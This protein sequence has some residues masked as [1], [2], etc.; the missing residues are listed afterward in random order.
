MQIGIFAKTYPGADPLTVLTR[1]AADGYACVQYNLACSGLASMPDSVS[2]EAIEAIASAS[3]AT[4]VRVVALSATYNMIHPDPDCRVLGMNR[5]GLSLEIAARLGIPTVTLCTGTRDSQDQWRHHPD[6]ETADAW[7]DLIDEMKKA[8]AKADALG[9]KLG[10]EPEQAN[11][12]RNAEDA[13]RLMREVA[14]P[15][16][17]IVLDPANLFEKA[18]AREARKIIAHAVDL[19]SDRIIMAHAKDRNSAGDFA[20]AGSGVVDFPEFIAQLVASG[21]DGPVVTHGLSDH[22]APEVQRYLAAVIA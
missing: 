12:V 2:D 1:A 4:G 22:E 19:L 10:I 20:T 11:V 3:R 8:A 21:F 18:A 15:S 17:G 7:R 5:L 6:N 9:L 14:S 16:L 13:L